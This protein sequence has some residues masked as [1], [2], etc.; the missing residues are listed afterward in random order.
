MRM[1]DGFV[2]ILSQRGVSANV[3]EWFVMSAG[4]KKSLTGT[5]IIPLKI[6]Y[7]L[8]S[9]NLFLPAPAYILDKICYTLIFAGSCLLRNMQQ[10]F[11]FYLIWQY[12]LSCTDPI[13]NKSIPKLTE[14]LK[15]MRSF[16]IWG[17]SL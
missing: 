3:F 13:R 8:V 4:V 10:L 6:V 9:L 2:Q 7:R 14:L 1:E 11:E 16:L 15:N 5:A 12:Q 17:T